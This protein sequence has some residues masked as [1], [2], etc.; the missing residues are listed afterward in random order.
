MRSLGR[1]DPV[2]VVL[3]RVDADY[4]DPLELRSDSQL[5]VPGLIEAGRAG[6]VSVVNGFGAGVLES[7]GGVRLPARDR[8]GAARRGPGDRRRRKPG[9]AARTSRRRHVLANLDGWC[10]KPVDRSE[11][12]FG[13]ELSAA[14]LDDLRRRIEADPAPGAPR[15]RWR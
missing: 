8:P 5:G 15:S 14:R 12:L 1:L 6:Q 9:G 4:A 2:D 13:W 3:R 11:G 7:P 10:V